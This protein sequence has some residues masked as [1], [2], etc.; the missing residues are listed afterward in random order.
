MR[1]KNT[2]SNKKAQS[3]YKTTDSDAIISNLMSTSIDNDGGNF[4]KGKDESF[5]NENTA[6]YGTEVDVDD[7]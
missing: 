4:I 2:T 6:V 1:I 3:T 7:L 5:R